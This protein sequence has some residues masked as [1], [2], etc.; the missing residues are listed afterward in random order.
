M[1]P[2]GEKL[3]EPQKQV[4]WRGRKGDG[5]EGNGRHNE[6]GDKEIGNLGS[7]LNGET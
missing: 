5:L 3:S 6:G 1:T 7:T 4:G 2:S